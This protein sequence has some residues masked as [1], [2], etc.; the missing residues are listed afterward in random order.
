M[1]FRQEPSE[2]QPMPEAVHLAQK[3]VGEL[4]WISGRSRFDNSFQVNWLSRLITRFLRQALADGEKILQY[5]FTT[6]D[7][8][9]CYQ[10]NAAPPLEILDELLVWPSMQ[11]CCRCGPA[12]ASGLCDSRVAV[13]GSCNLGTPVLPLFP[14]Y[15]GVSLLKLNSRKE[16]T[17]IKGLLG[18]LVALNL[19]PIAG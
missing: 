8:S 10:R 14:F 1:D 2:E 18:N 13:R 17:L 3:V 6:S 7:L 15:L 12:R 9:I 5:L 4:T 16:A 19:Q 11:I